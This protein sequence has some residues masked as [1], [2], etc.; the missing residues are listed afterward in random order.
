MSADLDKAI[1]H[2]VR[3]MLDVEPPADLRAKV[4]ARIEE[5]SRPSVFDLPFF[6]FSMVRLG[7]LI[8]AVALLVLAITLVRRSEPI[9]QAPSIAHAGDQQ[10]PADAP[11]REPVDVRAAQQPIVPAPRTR[12][13]RAAAPRAYP[14]STGTTN[15]GLAIDPLATISP[16]EVASIAP[17]SITPEPIGVRPLNPISE[18][19]I[20]PLNP[21]DGRD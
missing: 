21:P 7:A 19:Q 11:A 18:V 5:R 1:D 8:A 6:D 2:A 14:A 10:L 13:A 9:A 4:T 16:I 3:D 12:T 17:S 20:A 15:A